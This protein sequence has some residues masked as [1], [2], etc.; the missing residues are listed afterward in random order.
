M[1]LAGLLDSTGKSA[2]GS[3]VPNGGSSIESN[4]PG[5]RASSDAHVFGIDET[6]SEAESETVGVMLS[7]C[8]CFCWIKLPPNVGSK[9]LANEPS[10]ALFALSARDLAAARLTS[11]IW[12][13]R[14]IRRQYSAP[15][16]AI[17]NTL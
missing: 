15:D 14:A 16:V 6:E 10:A 3:V 4:E 8:W 2:F 1:D 11:L 5:I 13:S 9:P 17:E 7:T 12:V